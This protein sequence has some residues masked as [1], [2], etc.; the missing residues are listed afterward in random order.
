MLNQ[1]DSGCANCSVVDDTILSYPVLWTMTVNDWLWASGDA[2]GFLGWFAD[3][4]RAVIDAAVAG[5]LAA[6]LDQDLSLMGWDDRLANGW[7]G[8][9]PTPPD[10]WGRRHTHTHTCVPACRAT[11]APLSQF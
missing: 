6:P 9:P 3:D 10:L 4:V 5:T 7:C 2:A 8:A 1:T 11:I